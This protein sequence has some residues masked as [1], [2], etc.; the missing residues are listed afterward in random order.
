[1]ECLPV[2]LARRS[3]ST[4]IARSK[5]SI[6]LINSL[7]ISS[8]FPEWVSPPSVLSAI[9]SIYRFPNR[10][11]PTETTTFDIA[12]RKF[13]NRF[14]HFKH[15][16]DGLLQDICLF[17]DDFICDLVCK[18]QNALEPVQKPHRDLI[19]FILFLHE[20]NGRASALHLMCQ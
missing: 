2:C 12:A 6:T 20:L 10:R 19:V 13:R 16:R 5:S 9:I 3:V 4:S 18:R 17:T 7:P 14:H 1:M 8:I 11:L 15:P